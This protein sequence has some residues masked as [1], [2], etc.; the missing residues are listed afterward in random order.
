ME[1]IGNQG[2]QTAWGFEPSPP[3]E[4]AK[5]SAEVSMSS[6]FTKTKA[7]LGGKWLC[8]SGGRGPW[9]SAAAS[10]TE[11]PRGPERGTRSS[12]PFLTSA[13]KLAHLHG[14]ACERH[15]LGSCSPQ[16]VPP[17]PLQGTT[18]K[19]WW[20]AYGPC[21]GLIWRQDFLSSRKTLEKHTHTYTYTL[22]SLQNKNLHG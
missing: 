20:G 6:C 9:R 10:P 22:L 2:V 19:R 16:H 1:A 7:T 13:R 12:D 8:D 4:L 5:P 14:L 18:L 15:A 17:L 21:Q 11:P 3:R